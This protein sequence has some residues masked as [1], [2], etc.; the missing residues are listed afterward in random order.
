M[1]NK[2]NANALAE[3]SK[4][5]ARRVAADFYQHQ[6]VM[7]G[8][9][10]LTLTPIGQ[11]NLFIVSSL[12][13]KWRADAEKFRSPYFDFSH[14][15]VE[16]AL[17]G[18]MNTVSQHIAVRREHLEPLLA[19]STRKT[20]ILIFD[21]R[22][23]FDDLFRAQPDFTLST[24]TLRQTVRYTQIN[25]FIPTFISQRMNGK[26]FIYVNQALNY[27]DEAMTQRG[28]EVEQYDKF[29]ELFSQKAPLNVSVLL[30]KHVPDAIPAPPGRSFFDSDI[31]VPTV[32][33]GVLSAPLPELTRPAPT[34]TPE[35]TISEPEPPE[36]V[37][38][39]P[40]AAPAPAAARLTPEP[41]RTAAPEPEYD[42]DD[43]A[44]SQPQPMT[45]NDRLRQSAATASAVVAAPAAA[46]AAAPQP[47]P[48]AEVYRR[49]PVESVGKSISLNQKFRFINQ[50]F[51]GNSV[52]Y[53][54]A[55]EE[56]DQV[57][58]YGQA[59]DLISYRYASQHLW[60]MSSDEVGELVEILKRRF[61]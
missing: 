12:S 35:P 32:D 57:T 19:E 42:Y 1:S 54:Q 41:S 56:L 52:V 14:P 16:E 59:L 47:A 61:A 11:I 5:Y 55:I 51:N 6:S 29:V 46:P 43:E 27:L 33:S 50:L 23:Y 7:S 18:F 31:E 24:E 17:R 2:F 58:S 38:E 39:L 22:S 48:L 30:R 9:Q 34:P 53:S 8:K 37:M 10:I 40:A 20:L 49:A 60:D 3:Y 15:D 45:V 25:K 21:P 28:H 13:D 26:P 44:D 36:S 4:A